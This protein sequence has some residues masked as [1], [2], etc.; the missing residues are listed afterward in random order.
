V[1]RKYLEIHGHI[2]F[3]KDK[4][5]AAVE[6]LQLKS[7]GFNLIWILRKLQKPKLLN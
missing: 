5:G 3:K 1:K 2:A 7:Y 6:Y 4:I